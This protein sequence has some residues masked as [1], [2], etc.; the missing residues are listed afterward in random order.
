[1]DGAQATD[2][3][4]VRSEARS[5]ESS[6]ASSLDDFVEHDE[7]TRV[8]TPAAL[9]SKKELEEVLGRPLKDEEIGRARF[10][11]SLVQLESKYGCS[12]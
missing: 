7:D 2:A 3:D 5:S 10:Q 1:M 8:H 6:D 11:A 4:E 9:M 12:K